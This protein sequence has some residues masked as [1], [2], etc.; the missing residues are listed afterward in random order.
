MSHAGLMIAHYTAAALGESHRTSAYPLYIQSHVCT[1]ICDLLM[2]CTLLQGPLPFSPSVWGQGVDTSLLGWLHPNLG[3]TGGPCV[4]GRLCSTE[5]SYC[6]RTCRDRYM[7]VSYALPLLLYTIC[8]NCASYSVAMATDW[9]LGHVHTCRDRHYTQAAILFL[10]YSV[11]CHCSVLWFSLC[12]SKYSTYSMATIS[13][14]CATISS[15]DVMFSSVIG[16]YCQLFL[17]SVSL[18]C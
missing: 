16:G 11:P 10:L 17:D 8:V 14:P 18:K 6:C 15:R 2:L 4:H 7:V 5:G 9:I 13:H 1:C 12:F 3:R